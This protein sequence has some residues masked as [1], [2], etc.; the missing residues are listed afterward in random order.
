[1][2]RQ[3]TTGE[4]RRVLSFG[5]GIQT[6]ALALMLE[7][8]VLENA[9]APDVA[10]FADTGA[11][12]PH[13]YETLD[14]LRERISYPLRIERAQGDLEADVRTELKGIPNWRHR[15]PSGKSCDLPV[16]G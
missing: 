15:K 13:V 4:K 1:M 14:W 11:E 7:R 10:I 2:S 6:T 8:G 16:Y 9:P 3:T 12:P 5:G